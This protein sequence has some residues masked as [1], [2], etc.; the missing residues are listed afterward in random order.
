[1]KR[2]PLYDRHC[3]LGAKI[4]DFH[5][6]ALPLQYSG[7]IEEHRKVR[8][9]AGLFDVSHMGEIAVEGP[10]ATEFVQRII[11]NDISRTKDF[12]IV[13]SPMCN[14]DGGVVDDI[15]VYKF[16]S[17]FYLLVVNA[18]NTDKDYQWIMENFRGRVEVKNLSEEYAQMAVQGPEAGKILQKLVN[19][20]LE[21]LK[22]YNFV[23]EAEICGRKAIISRTG[24]TGE[25][26]F[27]IYVK[28][29]FAPVIWDSL[30]DAGKDCGL[31][32]AGLGARD[33]LRFEAALPLYGQELS[34]EITPLE[35]GLGRFVKLDKDDFIGKAALLKQKSTGVKR[36]IAGLEMVDRGIPRTGYDVT[37]DGVKIGYVTSGNFSPTLGKNLGMALVDSAYSEV[38]QEVSVVIRNKEL[39]ARIVVLP[40]YSKRYVKG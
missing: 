38:G 32:P 4:V 36:R 34:E 27:E 11:T 13:Y 28:S 20:R 12:R 15:L 2:T 10:D 21:E 19:I 29:E 22:F 30:L 18:S 16:S 9:A 24:Y 14:P 17:D 7:I 31:V 35:A 25:D 5:G 8:N 23:P 33:T 40:F 6:W 37:A 39:K 26:G 1:M 3:E